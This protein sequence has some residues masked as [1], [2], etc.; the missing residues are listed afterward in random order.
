MIDAEFPRIRRQ[1]FDDSM[2]TD[3]LWSVVESLI[4]TGRACQWYLASLINQETSMG[5]VIG[6]DLSLPAV[7]H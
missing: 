5:N 1:V 2:D 3:I 7:Q 4:A 6:V